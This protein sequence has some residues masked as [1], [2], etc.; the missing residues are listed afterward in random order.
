M[1]D[2]TLRVGSRTLQLQPARL[3]DGDIERAMRSLPI[4]DSGK[5]VKFLDTVFAFKVLDTAE[6]KGKPLDAEV[7]VI[8]LGNDIAWVG[9]PAKFSPNSVWRSRQASQFKTTI[10]AELGHGPVTYF[11]NEAAASQ[12]NY[13]VVTSRVATGSGERLVEAAKEL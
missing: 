1:S 9:C 3:K 13:E 7:Q 11:P 8:A 6:R 2:T 4:V 10:I 12:G 5:Q